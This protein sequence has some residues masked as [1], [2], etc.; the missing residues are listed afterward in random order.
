MSDFDR[1]KQRGERLKKMMNES[2]SPDRAWEKIHDPHSPPKRYP[3]PNFLTN[4]DVNDP[5]NF[6]ENGGNDEDEDFYDYLSDEEEKGKGTRKFESDQDD[7]DDKRRRQHAIDEEEAQNRIKELEKKKKIEEMRKKNEKEAQIKYQMQ[8]INKPR[9]VDPF[10]RQPDPPLVLQL[11][12][13]IYGAMYIDPRDISLIKNGEQKLSD[14]NIFRNTFIQYKDFPKGNKQRT[15]IFWNT[16][17]PIFNYKAYFPFIVREDMMALLSKFF[18]VFEVWDQIT[19]DKH[20]WVGFTKLSLS[21]FFKSL[22]FQENGLLNTSYFEDEGNAYPMV[23]FDDNAEIVNFEGKCV[24]WLKLTCALGSPN[25][26]NLF[27]SIQAE[28]D[29][30][31]L[32][33]EEEKK[34]QEKR[35][36]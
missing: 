15:L 33:E 34:R 27:D 31:R 6:N 16:N 19:A 1:I 8:Q 21:W 23:G 7:K 35:K 25:Q 2:L 24:G 12:L 18:F 5:R 17:S 30:T 4:P 29:R 26:V 9:V 3:N 11:Y 20:N 32:E 14:M 22:M 10:A 13:R 28:R 36:K